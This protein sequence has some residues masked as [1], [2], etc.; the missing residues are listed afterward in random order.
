MRQH[1]KESA[2]A[3]RDAQS[4]AEEKQKGSKNPLPER[5]TRERTQA[6]IIGGADL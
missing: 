3:S 1:S 4:G 2:T 6:E 5:Y